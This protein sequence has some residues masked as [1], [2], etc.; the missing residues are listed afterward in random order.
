MITETTSW[1]ELFWVVFGI[2]LKIGI[3]LW[4]RTVHGDWRHAQ[5]HHQYGRQKAAIMMM[6]LGYGLI[7]AVFLFTLGGIIAAFLP[8][9]GSVITTWSILL[10]LCFVLGFVTIGAMMFLFV[11]T[12]NELVELSRAR[13]LDLVKDLGD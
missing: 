13:A 10:G 6:V 11:R 7:C 3:A 1:I 12:Y 9:A 5:R 4:L 8:P 2:G